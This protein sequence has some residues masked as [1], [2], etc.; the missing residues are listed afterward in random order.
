MVKKSNDNRIINTA[1]VKAEKITVVNLSKV[2]SVPVSYSLNGKKIN[3]MLS[4]STRQ[5]LPSDARVMT[6]SEYIRV[7]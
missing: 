7:I 2:I 6:E 3:F 1:T 5:E 4:P